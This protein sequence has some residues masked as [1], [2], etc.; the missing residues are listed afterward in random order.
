MKQVLITID[1]EGHRGVDSVK[2]LIYGTTRDGKQYGIVR[3]MDLCDQHNVKAI[4]FVD[5][6]EVWD[7]GKEKIADVIKLIRQRGHFVGIHIHPDH[8]ADSKR[9]FLWEYTKEEQYEIIKK[10]LDFYSEVTNEKPIYFRAGK[11]GAN[12]DTLDILNELEVKYDFSENYGQKWCGINPPVAYNMPQK[13]KEIYE[14]PVTS[15][16][17]LKFG[18]YKRYD[19]IDGEMLFSEFKRVMR[20]IAND[21]RDIVVILFFHSFSL[22]NWRHNPDNPRYNL[23]GE[24]KFVKMLEYISKSQNFSFVTPD[25]LTIGRDVEEIDPKVIDTS[26]N[27]V[28]AMY[29]SF[30]RLI[31]LGKQ[32]KKARLLLSLIVFMGIVLSG[33][34]VFLIFFM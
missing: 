30:L 15:Y 27:V 4:F 3:I 13:Y 7:Y 34:I 11:Y 29:Y 32:N 19:K 28:I 6:A 5:I 20:K 17:S 10:C 26:R 2:R 25:K 9:L 24:K 18:K 21:K 31:K 33:V 22:L 8:M 12:Y 1:T 16:C 23:R 14:I